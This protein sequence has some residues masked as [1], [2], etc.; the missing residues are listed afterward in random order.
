MKTLLSF[1]PLRLVLLFAFL[2]VAHAY[3]GI[4]S[5][6]VLAAIIT[7]T[8]AP[9]I[10]PAGMPMKIAEHVAEQRN[11]SVLWG[12]GDSMLPLYARGTALIVEPYD[13]EKLKKGMTVVYVNRAG[14]RVAHC[15]VGETRG[16]YL[17]QGVNNPEEDVELLTEDNFLGVVVAAYGSTGTD[18]RAA[19]LAK[20]SSKSRD[21]VAQ[22]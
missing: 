22:R 4:T 7:H 9:E 15:V 21:L 6:R 18:F 11:A 2:G 16:G 8:P 13:Y 5:P 10:V 12:T 1:F 3:A 20:L 17:L 19:T 14:R